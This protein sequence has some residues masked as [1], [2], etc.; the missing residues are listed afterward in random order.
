[1]YIKNRKKVLSSHQTPDEIFQNQFDQLLKSIILDDSEQLKLSKF[2]YENLLNLSSTPKKEAIQIDVIYALTQLHNIK[3]EV[4]PLRL[5]RYTAMILRTAVK[6]LPAIREDDLVP[7]ETKSL[8]TKEIVFD[9]FVQMAAVKYSPGFETLISEFEEISEEIGKELVK[10]GDER[11]RHWNVRDRAL[12]DWCRVLIEATA[13]PSFFSLKEMCKAENKD[14]VL[15][16]FND[17]FE[18]LVKTVMWVSFPDDMADNYKH[19]RLTELFNN[20]PF[21]TDSELELSRK[22]VSEI[23]GGLFSKYFEHAVKVWKSAEA[24][25]ERIMGSKYAT[26]KHELIENYKWIKRSMLFSA[27]M[28]ANPRAKSNVVNNEKHLQHNMMATSFNTLQT[29]LC[30]E[31]I[32]EGVEMR[33]INSFTDSTFDTLR[34]IAQENARRSNNIATFMRELFEGDLSNIMFSKINDWYIQPEMDRNKYIVK[35]QALCLTHH[36]VISKHQLEIGKE[37][38]ESMTFFDLLAFRLDAEQALF[39]L[40]SKYDKDG[41][42]IE[43]QKDYQKA[44]EEIEKT[45]DPQE[46]SDIQEI[47]ILLKSMKELILYLANESNIFRIYYREWENGRRAMIDNVNSYSEAGDLPMLHEYIRG[48]DKVHITYLAMKYER[49]F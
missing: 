9:S 45:L 49:I 39:Q 25:F 28:N 46:L 44:T 15:Q 42:L 34:Q 2:V 47:K 18:A 33:L 29:M 3:A 4:P 12:W 16:R 11:G 13:H 1:M 27:K 19:V 8:M 26:H 5:A 17:L 30:L 41:K 23:D 35:I 22:E 48:W 14:E 43:F 31:L 36:A 10:K 32:D 21:A 40:Y 37:A 38:A 20:I 24:D 6:K 7:E